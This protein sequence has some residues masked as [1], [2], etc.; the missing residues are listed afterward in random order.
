MVVMAL[1]VA[2]TAV[3]AAVAGVV[4]ASARG[5]VPGSPSAALP[6]RRIVRP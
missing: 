1:R 2:G 3:V 5:R 6:P 4:T